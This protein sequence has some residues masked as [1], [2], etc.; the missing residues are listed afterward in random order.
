MNFVHPTQILRGVNQALSLSMSNHEV[1]AVVHEAHR[2]DQ[3]RKLDL[4]DKLF[5]VTPDLDQARCV[6]ACYHSVAGADRDCRDGILVVIRLA[7]IVSDYRMRLTQDLIL[8]NLLVVQRAQG[9]RNRSLL[10]EN[11]TMCLGLLHVTNLQKLDVTGLVSC[12]DIAA[13]YED[14]EQLAEQIDLVNMLSAFRTESTQSDQLRII[15]E[16]VHLGRS[17]F[18]DH[19]DFISADLMTRNR[20]VKLEDVVDDNLPSMEPHDH[21][22]VLWDV[23]SLFRVRLQKGRVGVILKILLLILLEVF[24]FLLPSI[25]ALEIALGLVHFLAVVEGRLNASNLKR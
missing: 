11:S 22:S 23:L 2:Q 17:H 7:Q 25:E 6:C 9:L 20:N 16:E 13:M 1:A 15:V 3:V 12:V 21:K 4:T 18:S 24:V 14:L 8:H 19:Q 5:L 10:S